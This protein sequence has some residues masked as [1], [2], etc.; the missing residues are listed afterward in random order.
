MKTPKKVYSTIDA[1]LADLPAPVALLMQQI[2]ETIQSV[3]PKATEAIKYD[4]PT[5]VQQGNLISF[6]AWKHHI[7]IYPVTSEME[8]V[9][10][11]IAA[12]ETSGKG[13]IRFPLDLPLPIDLIRDIMVFR[14]SNMVETKA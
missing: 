5:F 2:R 12:Y 14:L 13:T 9:I 6:A 7:A 11:A 3:A 1:Y 4:M 10:P 8:T